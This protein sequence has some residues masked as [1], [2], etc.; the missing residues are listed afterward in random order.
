VSRPAS[1]LRLCEAFYRTCVA[2]AMA[3]EFPRL[4]H[5]AGL[6][7]RGSEVLG[8]D[9]DM[10]TDHTWFARVIVFV[11]GEV[12][13]EQGESVQARLTAR[14]PDLFEGVPTEVKVTSV[15]QYF[16]D[17]LGMD[18]SVPWDAYDWV[19]L[20]EHLLRAMTAGAAFHDDLD[21]EQVRL[22][23][24]YYPRDVWLYLLLAGW[25]RVHP[26]VNLV[27]RAGYAGDDLGS[28]LIASEIVSG[29]MHLSFLIERRYAPY[30]KWFG[31][32]FS[33]LQIADRLS[34]PLDR[35][36]HARSWDERE[37]ALGSGYEI[38][39]DAFNDLSVVPRLALEPVRMWGRPFTVMWADFPDALR[40]SISDPQVRDLLERWPTGGID[41]VSE[42]LWAPQMRS[43]VRELVEGR[44]P[45]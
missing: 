41:R 21:L 3:A 29:L 9:D 23:L 13:A 32:A 33:E 39:A 45:V 30:A 26:E 14:V 25:W 12:L 38:V 37:K 15:R 1:G 18:V 31:T 36:L 27:G 35:A 44:P 5:A 20:P 42:I 2:P 24:A 17:L 22:R 16:L 11:P 7:G 34:G 28:T 10:S 19:S 8:Y 40:A 6:M 4:R 43:R